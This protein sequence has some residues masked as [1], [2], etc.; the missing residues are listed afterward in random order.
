MLVAFMIAARE[1]Y[2]GYQL[3]SSLNAEIEKL[4]EKQPEPTPEEPS[5]KLDFDIETKLKEKT[6]TVSLFEKAKPE[7]PEERV[8]YVEK[9]QNLASIL[10]GLKVSTKDVQASIKVL[11]KQFNVNEI[12]VGQALWIKLRPDPESSDFL[13]ESLRIKPTLEKEIILTRTDKGF[14]VEKKIIPLTK[15]TKYIKGNVESGFYKAAI[16]FGVPPKI[17]KES[18]SALAYIVNMQHTLKKGDPFEILYEEF[19][20]ETG[21]M[22]K[23]GSVL[24]VSLTS[25]SKFYQLYHYAPNGKN[26]S[27]YNAKGECVQRG[28]LQTPIDPRKMKVTSH[29]QKGRFHPLKGYHRDHKGVDFGAP[30][31][32]TVMAAADGVVVKA[33]YFG[34]Y[35]KYIRIQHTAGYQTAY[36]HLSKI[37]DNV[38]VGAY[39]RQRDPIG[40]VGSTGLASGPHLHYEVIHNNIHVN[41]LN[42]KHMPAKNLKGQETIKFEH[43][44]RS[45]Q[46]QIP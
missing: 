29:F 21:N 37:Y 25:S 41:P 46:A 38:K 16:K 43:F 13:L 6:D 17:A 1:Y 35:G 5:E 22:V 34:D 18:I 39:V 4:L 15:K 26:F 9:K 12:K 10:T 27:Y 8:F 30:T 33:G 40:S 20:D 31:G 14:H 32:T 3:Q 23:T 24:Y 45:I 19:Y 11:K 28:L 42:V 36:A 44:K 2:V 7:V